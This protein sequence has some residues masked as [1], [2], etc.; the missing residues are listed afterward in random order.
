MGT[1]AGWHDLP[2]GGKVRV[3]GGVPV[4]VTDEGRWD[5]DEREILTEAGRLVD[6]PLTWAKL[7]RAKRWRHAGLT[8]LVRPSN[9]WR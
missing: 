6:M 7:D 8:S 9:E 5:L 2:R 4:E 1:R 3:E